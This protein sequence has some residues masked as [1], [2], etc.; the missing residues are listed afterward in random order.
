MKEKKWTDL[1]CKLNAIC[2]QWKDHNYIFLASLHVFWTTK[3]QIQNSLKVYLFQFF[4]K[5][6][7]FTPLRPTNLNLKISGSFFG[8]SKNLPL[9]HPLGWLPQKPSKSGT[10]QTQFPS[11]KNRILQTN[12]HSIW[13]HEFSWAHNGSC[14]TICCGCRHGKG[15]RFANHFRVSNA[16][17]RELLSKA[18]IWVVNTVLMILVSDFS[19]LFKCATIFLTMLLCSIGKQLKYETKGKVNDNTI[20][21]LQV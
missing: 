3:L 9:S 4:L 10:V 11:G 18:S 13:F 1:G 12:L 2:R 16:V 15:D 17:Q 21:P 14:W 19:T 8:A 20:C 6:S 5:S 7:Y